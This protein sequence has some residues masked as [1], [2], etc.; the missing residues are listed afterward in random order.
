MNKPMKRLSLYLFLILFTLPTPSQADDISDFEIE[1]ISLGDSALDYFSKQEINKRIENKKFVKYPRSDSYYGMSFR[2][3]DFFNTYDFV[4]IHMK[5]NDKKFK[6]VGVSGIINYP[7][8]FEDC[9]KERK[10]I[11]KEVEENFTINSSRDYTDK[12]GGK[13]GKSIAY[14]TDFNFVSGGAIRIWC[15][16]WDKQNKNTKNWTDDLNA[17]VSSKEFLDFLQNEAY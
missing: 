3:K 11:V 9:L 4:K 8:N 15:T 14:I 2:N 6:I 1:G 7:N 17:G 13:G 16:K 12:F 5:K 10:K